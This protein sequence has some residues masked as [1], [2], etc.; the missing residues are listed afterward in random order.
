M[1]RWQTTVWFACAAASVKMSEK[2]SSCLSNRGEKTGCYHRLNEKSEN[3]F[4]DIFSQQIFFLL[5]CFCFCLHFFQRQQPPMKLLNKKENKLKKTLNGPLS[6]KSCQEVKSSGKCTQELFSPQESWMGTF[7]NLVTG[8]WINF[9][10]HLFPPKLEKAETSRSWGYDQD[11]FLLTKM[12]TR[13]VCAGKNSKNRFLVWLWNMKQDG[14]LK[15]VYIIQTK[16][17]NSEKS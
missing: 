9:Q 15:K 17:N 3:N 7:I 10:W 1:N 8:L 2:H 11:T 16:C 5:T 13:T 6:T 14:C 4:S 12:T